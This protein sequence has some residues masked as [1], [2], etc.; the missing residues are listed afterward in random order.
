[1]WANMLLFFVGVV[2]VVVCVW[3]FVGGRCLAVMGGG[4]VWVGEYVASI[5]QMTYNR[6]Q[7]HE[8]VMEMLIIKSQN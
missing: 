6:N 2:V 1:M 3:V 4:L 7:H 5:S 8:I